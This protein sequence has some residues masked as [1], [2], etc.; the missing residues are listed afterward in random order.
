MA[1]SHYGDGWK[2]SWEPTGEEISIQAQDASIL[3]MFNFIARLANNLMIY[4]ARPA[5][6]KN[7]IPDGVCTS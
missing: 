6:T 1:L 2:A 3:E 7:L 5:P 4:K